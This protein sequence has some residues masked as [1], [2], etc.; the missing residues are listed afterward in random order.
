MAK[1]KSLA[2]IAN[3]I[4][5][6]E[7]T[8]SVDMPSPPTVTIDTAL[9]LDILRDY[10]E[11]AEERVLSALRGLGAQYGLVPNVENI[12]EIIQCKVNVRNEM[13]KKSQQF[14][15]HA[16]HH[17]QDLLELQDLGIEVPGINE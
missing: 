16:A 14:A 7:S 12:Q 10:H 17:Y 8:Q 13:R 15:E 3:L 9:F 11:L 6:I 4:S 2:E 5:T 1:K